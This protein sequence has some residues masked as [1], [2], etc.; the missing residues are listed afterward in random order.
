M[1]H[2]KIGRGFTLIE[3]LV[4]IAI[5]AVHNYATAVG[6]LP[7]TGMASG[8]YYRN[9]FSMKAR[10]LPYLEQ[11]AAFNAL[12][13]GLAWNDRANTTVDYTKISGFVCP[14]DENEPDGTQAYTNYP[15]NIGISRFL[16]GNKFDGPA[17]MLG[18]NGE[19]PVMTIARVRDG[20][21]NTALF[22]EW[23][24]GENKGSGMQDGLHVVYQNDIATT[25]PLAQLAPACQSASTRNWDQKGQSWLAHDT[26]RGGGYS[27]IMTPNKKAC[28]YGKNGAPADQ[29]I[30][31]ASSFH[32]GGV[33]V[34]L[35]DGSVKFIK[36]SVSPTVW[37]A[38][39]T[40][41]G[42]EVVS[43][44]SF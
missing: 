3:L 1:R 38:I 4:V 13:M 10:L 14:S 21:S 39:A 31:G 29:T 44:D 15:N 43:A 40:Y 6:S 17:Y 9:Y 20:T 18:N 36:E 2:S 23:I 16:N 8:N 26:G 34:T 27:H 32:P 24:M 30:I 11:T 41:A 37:W 19:G 33:N 5:I 22:S 12:N 25:T 35:M 7:P 28:W 42:K